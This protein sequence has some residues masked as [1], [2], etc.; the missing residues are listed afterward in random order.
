MPTANQFNRTA[1]FVREEANKDG[2]RRIKRIPWDLISF[3]DSGFLV[4]PMPVAPNMYDETGT[5]TVFSDV[6]DMDADGAEA[7]LI[8]EV[9]DLMFFDSET[10]FYSRFDGTF[11][12]YTE[13]DAE[14]AE[15][16]Y[17][18]ND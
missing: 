4:S 7:G 18:R 13:N 11:G 3:G 12:Y 5:A 6:L 1:L 2:R 8:D 15:F 10:D 9:V 14:G 17:P 16:G